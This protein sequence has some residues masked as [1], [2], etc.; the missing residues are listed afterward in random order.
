MSYNLTQI[1]TNTTGILGMTQGINEELMFGWLGIILLIG[2]S[3]II[4]IAFIKT[5]GNTQK[6]MTATGF[7][8]F[9]LA[10]LLRAMQLITNDLVLFITLI[11]CAGAIAITWRRD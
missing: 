5:T 9:I 8:T 6:A 3:A 11:I 1:A 10:L 2:L 7:I 4:F